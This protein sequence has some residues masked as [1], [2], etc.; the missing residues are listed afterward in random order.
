MKNQIWEL[1]THAANPGDVG[2]RQEVKSDSELACGLDHSRAGSDVHSLIQQ[3]FMEG[4]LRDECSSR[5]LGYMSQQ[6]GQKL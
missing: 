4:P 6:K 3:I 1:F 5:R 2:S